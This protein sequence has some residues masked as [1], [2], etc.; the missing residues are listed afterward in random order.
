MGTI[1]M[2]LENSKT[3]K[4]HVLI[5]KLTNKLDLTLFRIEGGANRGPL[6]QFFPC[7]FYKR[8]N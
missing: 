2:N 5:L 1:F 7:N 4:R 8:K 3:S 6:Y